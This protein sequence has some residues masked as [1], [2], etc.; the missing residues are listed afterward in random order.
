MLTFVRLLENCTLTQVKGKHLSKYSAKVYV[1]KTVE[2][3]AESLDTLAGKCKIK[4]NVQTSFV[5]HPDPKAVHYDVK[6]DRLHSMHYIGQAL[7][8]VIHGESDK[9][10]CNEICLSSLFCFSFVLLSVYSLK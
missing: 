1:D 7:S 5:K 6:S 3:K 8:F 10:L 2:A 9:L 4:L